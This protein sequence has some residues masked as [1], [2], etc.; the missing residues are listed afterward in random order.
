MIVIKDLTE[1]DKGR[2]VEYRANAMHGQEEGIITSWN[3]SFV[4]VRYGSDKGS[5][6]TRPEDL[7]FC[8]K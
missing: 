7:D 3:D 2:M 4:L 8:I 5:K 6:A 1:N